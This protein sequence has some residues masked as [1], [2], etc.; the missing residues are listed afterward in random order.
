MT[1]QFGIPPAVDGGPDDLRERQIVFQLARRL[2]EAQFRRGDRCT[3]ER[4]WQEVAAL[5]IDPERIVALLYGVDDPGDVSAL[6]R[7]DRLYRRDRRHRLRRRPWPFSR[8]SR[9]HPA[10]RGGRGRHEPGRIQRGV[11]APAGV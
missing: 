6:E 9:F 3:T 7:V 11:Q 10:G 2:A 1:T 4:L 5:G 8:G